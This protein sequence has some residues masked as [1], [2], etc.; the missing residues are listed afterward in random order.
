MD[1]G[2]DYQRANLKSVQIIRKMENGQTENFKV[3]LQKALKGEGS[4]PFPL[5]PFDI[6]YV[7][8]RFNWF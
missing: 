6:I 5:K 2:V 3:N 1:A 7:P 4:E 8:E